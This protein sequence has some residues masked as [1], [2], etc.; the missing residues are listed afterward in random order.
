[1]LGFTGT[2][3]ADTAVPLSSLA[4]GAVVNFV[5]YNWIVLDPSTG[6]MLMQDNYSTQPFSAYNP[7][8]PYSF[9]NVFD[10]NNQF[11]IG[12]Y[13][14]NLDPSQFSGAGFYQRI[15][16]SYPDYKSLIIDHTFDIMGTDYLGNDQAY[17]ST[18]I[19]HV[20]L[21]SCSEWMKY[22]EYY[23]PGSGILDTPP[24]PFWTINPEYQTSYNDINVTTSGFLCSAFSGQ[25][26][27]V[28]PT[29]YL[30]PNAL[31]I[32]GNVTYYLAAGSSPIVTGI[33]TTR[34]S[35]AG[36]TQVTLT[37]YNFTGATGVSFGS[38]AASSFT[39][40]NDNTITAT[41]PAQA[42]G[43]VH[44]T[45]TGPFGT[46]SA[47]PTDQFVYVPLPAVTYVSPA[48]GLI[49]GGAVVNITGSSFTYATGV[50]FGGTAAASF[51]I[52]SDASIT[53]T[54]PAHAAGTA[55]VTVTSQGGTSPANLN[56]Q[57]EYGQTPEVT[58]L[59]PAI[60]HISGGTTVTITGRFFT[61]AT[62]VSFGGTAAASFTVNSDTS[63]TATSPAHADGTADV[64]V[65]TPGGTTSAGQFTYST[66]DL[67]GWWKLG[68]G[69]GTTAA[70]SS[71]YGLDGTA[72]NPLD[73][74][75]DPFW[76]G[77]YPNSIDRVGDSVDFS[78]GVSSFTAPVPTTATGS[79]SI[80]AWVKWH[81]TTWVDAS[82]HQPIAY[83]GTLEAGNGY[84]L[85]LTNQGYLEV[86]SGGD[87][88]ATATKLTPNIW[89]HVAG[90]EDGSGNWAVYLNGSQ[91]G[92]LNTTSS[93]PNGHMYI[94]CF[95]VQSTMWKFPG[96]IDNVRIYT[97]AL[98]AAQVQQLA[99]T[100]PVVTDVSPAIGL[101]G[102]G[103]VVT[104]AGSGFSGATGVSFGGTAAASFTVNSDTSI[105]ATSPAQ[106]T[107]TID[108]TVTTALGGTSAAVAADRFIYVQ[109]PS[110]TGVSPSV[111]PAAGGTVVT[112]T[113]SSFTGATGVS[114][115][116]TAAAK[117]TVNSDASITAVSPV[118]A[119]GTADVT[120]TGL[121]GTSAAGQFFY[122]ANALAA[123]WK[124]DE[125]AGTAAADS[126]GYGYHGA[127]T[128]PVWCTDH[129]ISTGQANA[130]LDFSGGGCRFSSPL[131]TVLTNSVSLSAWVKWNG[132][133]GISNYQP[134][135]HNGNPG[136]DG[137]G[138]FLDDTGKLE[139]L[140]GG[141]AWLSAT[142]TLP[143]NTWAHVAAVEDGS[144]NWI[145]Y[146][147]GNQAGQVFGNPKTPSSNML[148]GYTTNATSYPT[149]FPGLIS[150]VRIYAAALTPVQVQ[151]LASVY[152][153][154]TGI[155][156]ASG[157]VSGGTPVT[158]T[159]SGFI[160]ATGVSFG[161]TA[162]AGFTVSSDS[163]ITATSPAGSGTVD[164]TVT[165][166]G[167]S[168]ATGSSD[169]FMYTT[170]L[171]SITTPSAITGV[172]NGT[173]K[174]MSALGLPSTVTM[175]TDNGNV[176]ANVTWDV[177]GSSYNNNATTGQTFTVGGIVTLPSLVVN[178][179][180]VSL[181]TSISVSVNAAASH[182][183]VSVTFDSQGGSSAAVVA[184]VYNEKI[185]APDVPTKAN[186]VF[187]G[188]YKESS[189]TNA[190][191]FNSDTVT[192]DL[193][194]YAKWTA[195]TDTTYTLTYNAGPNG[196]IIGST[197]QTVNS[198]TTGSA[199]TAVANSGYYFVNWSDN[200]TTA[201]RTDSNV[202]RNI[203]VTANFAED[204]AG[205]G[206]SLTPPPPPPPTITG[207]VVDGT[208]GAKVSDI[209]A[210]VTTDANGTDTVTMNA[211]QTVG[212]KQPDGTV[213]PITD[214]S[215]VTITTSTGAAIPVAAD[216]TILVSNLAKGTDN[217]FSISY[218]LGNGQKIIMGTMNITV[219]NS[220]NVTLTTTLIDPYGIITDEATGKIIS[221]V[222][223]TLYY[224]DTER[225]K[226]A[227]KTPDTV[228][229]LPSID[230]FK[231]NNNADPQVS[232]TSGAYGFMVFPNSD[233][234]IMA[235]R[236]GY[237]KYT[238]PT[239]SVGQDIVKWDFKMNA[240]TV[241]TNGDVVNTKTGTVYHAADYNSNTQIYNQMIDQI[242]EGT[243]NQFTYEYS[244][245]QFG[246]DDYSNLVTKLLG[247][248]ETLTQAK[249]DAVQSCKLLN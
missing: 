158:I 27:N 221:G 101:I 147:N 211:S 119:D 148:I 76:S 183:P 242:I 127:L 140:C 87:W 37:G 96:L 213:S 106:A 139:I 18:A 118:H 112:I 162:A 97:T 138:L 46:S 246:L 153:A 238:S 133:T 99:A 201:T 232:D 155:S 243:T 49:S 195:V 204:P 24:A 44:V 58:G 186:S 120:V 56:D 188:W 23:N 145:V 152:P 108:V 179:N 111:G 62:A 34:G 105:T 129:P 51:T 163:S 11:S 14:N 226:A 40:N 174:T 137:Y 98:T 207:G 71:G 151:Q 45:V 60:G 115:G 89:Q 172:A 77:E 82:V 212:L 146:L 109:V 73:V 200:L 74:G 55:D 177:N 102:G 249:I 166:P 113:G 128:G 7:K 4:P 90:V 202:T 21:L 67:A 72:T 15:W 61:G 244:G 42:A 197:P 36:G 160:G 178:P 79:V 193:T 75:S 81:G 43:T 210:T 167:G 143:A 92:Q 107:G 237:V 64:T 125:G 199:I 194:L 185:S 218:D 135:A 180:N 52:N 189:C 229:Q 134:I 236:D 203:N 25:S 85:A 41:A 94:G 123:W 240:I 8:S 209:T 170:A 230:G 216:G 196:R 239:I 142:A 224:A 103:T 131:P 30:N 227:G 20:G 130:S 247:T 50:S 136:A 175:A 245:K 169:Q 182:E 198:G 171:V 165:T 215:K 3:R 157:P 225:N 214:T 86:I 217:N 222:N 5:G 208:T 83:N 190:W 124:L 68:E 93:S 78:D 173:A 168:S 241:T 223:V 12:Y 122:S 205:G 48:S 32:S 192:S 187:S 95:N 104:I 16:Y 159:G 39:V 84:G 80:S 144:G 220:G 150:D 91:V 31:I 54:S 33:S 29:L 154:V 233:Y 149:Y 184:A 110:I 114:F 69:S 126:S 88:L 176:P 6:Y 22:S 219:D 121:G 19:T 141:L 132:T 13:L 17:V 231:P 235:T 2:A 66:N 53:A 65:T 117:F 9:Y 156:P 10:P 63:I 59:S 228:V 161:G 191:N 206:G 38:V 1:M 164:V 47:F 26:E 181:T 28:R 57:F 100:F 35:F 70:D 116:G 234:Y 248:G